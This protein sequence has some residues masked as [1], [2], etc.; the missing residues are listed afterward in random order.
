MSTSDKQAT[1]MQS[2]TRRVQKPPQW[3]IPTA[4][5]LRQEA[6]V[7]RERAAAHAFNHVMAVVARQIQLVIEAGARS[8]STTVTIE[9][10]RGIP[11]REREG[12]IR[13]AVA[14]LQGLGYE[15]RGHLNGTAILLDW[16]IVEEAEQ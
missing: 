2:A 11:E 13:K 9:W 1:T 14:H 7:T 12:A 8:N 4:D 16:S 15:T 3:S 5:A 6:E 10:P